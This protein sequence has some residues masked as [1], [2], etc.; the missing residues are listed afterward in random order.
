MHDNHLIMPASAN[1]AHRLNRFFPW[2]MLLAA[3]ALV[4][5]GL[6]A[7]AS[8]S[9]PARVT[10]SL[11]QIDPAQVAAV[12]SA[13]GIRISHVAVTGG[14]GLV[15]VR[16]QVVDPDKALGIH[17]PESRPILI[18]EAS[19]RALDKPGIHSAHKVRP[20]RAGGTYYL[21]YQNNGGL[22]KPGSRVTI[23]IGEVTLEHVVVI[24]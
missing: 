21:L 10:A 14:G 5:L 19:G 12:E 17:D 11:D 23:R 9:A 16:Y 2:W 4:A 7:F 8:R 15:D 3:T 22:L 6:L 18:D 24:Q 1:P 13:W 20:M